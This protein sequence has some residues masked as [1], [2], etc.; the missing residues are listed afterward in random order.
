MIYVWCSGLL[1]SGLASSYTK[2]GKQDKSKTGGV[3]AMGGCVALKTI[4]KQ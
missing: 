4:C 3:E 1:K 2:D